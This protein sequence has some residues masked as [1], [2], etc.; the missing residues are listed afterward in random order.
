[1]SAHK[2]NHLNGSLFFTPLPTGDAMQRAIFL[3]SLLFSWS[4]LAQPS[5]PLTKK[6]CNAM[7]NEAE[8][9]YRDY[10]YEEALPLFE[11]GFEQCKDSEFLAYAGFSLYSLH[12]YQKAEQVFNS[13]L[14]DFKKGK[15]TKNIEALNKTIPTI[16]QTKIVVTTTPPGAILWI[17]DKVSPPIGTSPFDGNS[18]IGP[19]TIIAELEGYARAEVL[20]DIKQGS[21]TPVNIT[22]K[23]A[24]SKISVNSDPQGADVLIDGAVAG[25]TPYSGK[26]PPGKHEIRVT[27]SGFGSLIYPIEASKGKPFDFQGKLP[28]PVAIL[29][30]VLPTD[31]S[32]AEIL[33]NNKPVEKGKKSIE[34][35]GG[36]H[37]I[38]A[39]APGFRVFQTTVAAT[40]GQ[41]YDIKLEPKK[42][43]L[44]IDV[45]PNTKEAKILA[46]GKEAPNQLFVPMGKSLSVEVTQAG[47]LPYRKTFTAKLDQ[48]LL[49]AV[50][51]SPPTIDKAKTRAKTA[52]AL[53]VVG[54]G[55]ATFGGI[56]YYFYETE[57]KAPT[58]SDYVQIRVSTGVADAC[59]AATL[60]TSYLAFRL[61]KKEKA[62]LI[63]NSPATE[64]VAP[65]R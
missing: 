6:K 35:E 47:K 48:D 33:V 59:L 3:L 45:Q 53:G 41:S 16:L 36:D 52:A 65:Q 9:L 60:L 30:F 20:V 5:G 51:M 10:K 18:K 55:A 26:V 39:K 34:V 13:Y 58:Y 40:A 11:K 54:L 37:T 64:T 29:S 43:G 17:D 38:V 23:E 8:K 2:A 1:M 22:L 56:K 61:Y 31:I 63:G 25:V 28:P 15:S 32:D 46:A 19:R 12:Q 21:S 57:K 62:G 24:S 14:T 4:A 50:K 49:L 7:F 27:K 44:Y 42:Q